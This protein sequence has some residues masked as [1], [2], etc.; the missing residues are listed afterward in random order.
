MRPFEVI[1]VEV[2][3]D[4]VLDS[5]AGDGTSGHPVG[6]RHGFPGDPLV[7]FVLGKVVEADLPR[8]HSVAV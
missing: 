1:C 8:G 7:H 3:D 4:A 6:V 5:G 2:H